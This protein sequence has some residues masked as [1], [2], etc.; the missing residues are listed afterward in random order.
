MGTLGWV[1][2]KETVQAKKARLKAKEY[3]KVQNEKNMHKKFTKKKIIIDNQ[4]VVK[5]VSSRT[6]GL[7]FASKV[8]SMQEKKRKITMKTSHFIQQK[9]THTANS[10]NQSKKKN[11]EIGLQLLKK[12][13]EHKEAVEKLR[14]SFNKTA[15]STY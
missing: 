7:E 3:A 9:N 8:K 5:K 14:K 6:K 2:S 15:I 11:E 4:N 1:E 10:N 12:H 13:E